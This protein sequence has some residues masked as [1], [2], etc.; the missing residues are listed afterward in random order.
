[1]IWKLTTF[2]EQQSLH[3]GHRN[4]DTTL[5]NSLQYLGHTEDDV[6]GGAENLRR[7][8]CELFYKLAGHFEGDG[9]G[10][11]WLSS[12]GLENNKDGSSEKNR[13]AVVEAEEDDLL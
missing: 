7:K 8:L 9:G 11:F 2:I 1:L 12:A 4:L 13:I 5:V 6:V 10:S 3:N